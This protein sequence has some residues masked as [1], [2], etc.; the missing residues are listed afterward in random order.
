[1]AETQAKH[2]AVQS[3]SQH[4]PTEDESPGTATGG[5][6]PS[7]PG[8]GNLERTFSQVF[9]AVICEN[10]HTELRQVVLLMATVYRK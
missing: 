5:S 7:K 10:A 4:K 9:L 6:S 2:D 8:T 1:M 3:G